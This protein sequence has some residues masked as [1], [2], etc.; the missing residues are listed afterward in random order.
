MN[1]Q[2][3]ECGRFL[4]N[5]RPI[6]RVYGG[7]YGGGLKIGDVVGLC[8]LHGLVAATPGWMHQWDAWS[9]PEDSGL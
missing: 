9:W 1:A 2:C 8:R 5:A 6:V 4:S 7:A 3:K